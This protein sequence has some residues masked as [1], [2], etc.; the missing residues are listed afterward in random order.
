MNRIPY[1]TLSLTV[2]TALAIIVP[3]CI[4]GD[5]INA[6]TERLLN[7]SGA[8]P[9]TTGLALVLLLA[10]DIVLPVPSSLVST[11]CG[12]A[13]GFFGGA[14]TSFA[15]MTVSAA[16]GYA[17]GRYAS[18]AAGK[19]IGESETETLR[20]FH[21]RNGVWLLLALRAVPA[22]AEAS[23][24]F[25]GLARMPFGRT[26]AATTLGN[27]AVSLTYAAVG[28]WGRHADSF[29]PAFGVSILISALFFFGL[30]HKRLTSPGRSA[31]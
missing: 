16:I 7:Q 19:L 14:A 27:A 31:S 21:A 8:H 13:F 30:R 17:I 28:A 25:S 10:S 6:W 2:L 22:L 9:M 4:W 24:L 12:M 11:A 5:G 3:F 18:N 29:I 1:K 20:T 26:A 23:V 15:G